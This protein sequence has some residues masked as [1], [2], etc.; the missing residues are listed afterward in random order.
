VRASHV[1]TALLACCALAAAP[2]RAARSVR[3]DPSFAP[4]R[5]GHGATVSFGVQL[6]GAESA[7]APLTEVAVR[8]PAGL[9]IAL[10]GLGLDTCTQQRLEAAGPRGCPADSLMG[11]GSAI[12]EMFVGPSIVREQAQIAIVRGPEREGRF[13]MLFYVAGVQP[14]IVKAVFAGVL[15]PA[16]APFGGSIQI[17]LPV[18]QGLPGSDIAVVRLHVELGPPQLT[19]Y[20]RVRGKLVAYHPRRIALPERCPRGGFPFSA[21]LAFL[22]GTRAEASTKVHCPGSGTSNAAVIRR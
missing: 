21:T 2:A 17:E 16:P 11:N 22:D 18:I 13:A 8:Y 10:S 9:Q 14:V 1:L 15:L 5:L 7:L 20:E 12:T 3:L 6:G 19:Y 4:E